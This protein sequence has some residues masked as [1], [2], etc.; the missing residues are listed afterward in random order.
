MRKRTAW[1]C[2]VSAILV[3]GGYVAWCGRSFYLKPELKLSNLPPEV[4]AVVP[5]LAEDS[6]MMKAERFRLR[7]FWG[8][9]CKPY[10][11]RFNEIRVTHHDSRLELLAIKMRGGST[12]SF[13][14]ESG[15]WVRYEDSR[16]YRM[17]SDWQMNSYGR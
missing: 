10:A 16:Q 9:L 6:D 7:A 8:Y 14:Q 1:V 2:C 17:L 12:A 15:K 5:R 3:V 13:V 11:G 4:A